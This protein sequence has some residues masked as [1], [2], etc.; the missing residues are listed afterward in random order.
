MVGLLSSV[1]NIQP[2]K[3]TGLEPGL[4]NSIH[5]SLVDA[6]VPAQ[7]TSLIRSVRAGKA[8]PAGEDVAVLVGEGV[9]DGV[10]VLA[11]KRQFPVKVILSNRKVPVPAA[12]APY[13]Y[14]RKVALGL[15]SSPIIVLR[16]KVK[17]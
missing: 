3:L 10:S 7:A 12:P 13:P 5:S 2:A 15:L 14:K 17:G 8:V 16:S 11:G 4:Y 1:F 9:G 6:A